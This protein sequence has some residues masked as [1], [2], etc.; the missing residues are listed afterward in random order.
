MFVVS[1][2]GRFLYISETVSI[3]LG[4]SQVRPKH[5]ETVEYFMLGLVIESVHFVQ[6]VILIT[7]Y[8]NVL[9]D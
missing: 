9:I 5:L 7:P 8:N 1:Q 2:E 6:L 4:L 3:Y